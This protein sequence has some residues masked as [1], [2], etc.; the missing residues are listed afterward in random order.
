MFIPRNSGKESLGCT[1]CLGADE[2]E[3]APAPMTNKEI[4][5]QFG[6]QGGPINM[7]PVIG[8]MVT[9]LINKIPVVGKVFGGLFKKATHMESCMKWWTDDNLRTQVGAV[10]PAS[11]IPYTYV[12][13]DPKKMA[14]FQT[15]AESLMNPAKRQRRLKEIYVRLVRS[16]PSA[17]DLFYATCASMPQGQRET[18]A[19]INR[20]DIDSAWAALRGAAQQQEYQESVGEVQRLIEEQKQ[21]LITAKRAEGT[22]FVKKKD[23]KT[24]QEVTVASPIMPKGVVGYT[25]GG[26]AVIEVGPAVVSKTFPIV[27][28]K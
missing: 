16:Q 17:N 15:K 5:M 27:P 28:K 7:I 10:I 20:A 4:Q 22:F 3:Q 26:A 23:E 9:G 11:S 1:S 12:S 6:S 8:P 25:K 18:G 2:E 19:N 21:T 14:E 13:D 24:G